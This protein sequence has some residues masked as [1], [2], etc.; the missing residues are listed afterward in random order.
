MCYEKQGAAL[1]PCSN[2]VVS[3][4]ARSQWALPTYVDTQI[5]LVLA[6]ITCLKDLATTKKQMTRLDKKT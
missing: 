6:G 3:K 2:Q 4:S 5:S 1:C